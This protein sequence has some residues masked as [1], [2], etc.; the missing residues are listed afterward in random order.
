VSERR[1]DVPFVDL[2]AGIGPDRDQYLQALA[3]V[4][5]SARFSGG[6]EVEAFEQEFAALCGARHAAAVSS[7]TDALILALRALGVARGD[8]V[9]V[10]P[11]SFFATAGAVSWCGARPVFADVRED[12]LAIDAA[13]VERRLSPKT[14]AVVAVH[15]F[16]QVADMDALAAVAGA[17][18]F[19]LLEDAAQ[20]HGA[21]RAGET[22]GSI[23]RAA[24]FSFYPTKNLGAFGEGGAVTTGDDEVAARVLRL[25]DHGQGEKHVH[26][27]VGKNAR[28]AAVQ[29]ACLRIRLRRLGEHN[30]ARRRLAAAYRERL[31]DVPG[32]RLCAEDPGTESV[33]HLFVVRVAERDRIR[34][35]L[36]AA[37]I[38][39][40]IHYPTPI[41]LQPAY[42]ALGHRPGDFPV[43]ERAAR[44]MISLP[45]YPELPL[46]ALD[47]VCDALRRALA[48]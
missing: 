25:R 19:A 18:A 27:E 44:E 26:E 17:R 2:S 36:A 5:D 46:D 41:H 32:V 23:G 43:A 31:E 40:Q 12:T 13:E 39:T 28:L 9:I 8:E 3:G 15:L 34:A 1:P 37:G 11:N 22:A 10:P 48:G 45:M 4:M 16:G 29:A 33:H 38:G 24:A 6:P 14:R 47:R 42:E 7:G 20:A 21:R 35:A 30:A